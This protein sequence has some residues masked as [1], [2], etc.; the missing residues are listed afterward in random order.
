MSK[1]Q[2]S[3]ARVV[4]WQDGRRRSRR[5]LRPVRRWNSRVLREFQE[6]PDLILAGRGDGSLRWAYRLSAECAGDGFAAAVRCG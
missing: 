5:I 3:V 4:R 2:F 1:L 6:D